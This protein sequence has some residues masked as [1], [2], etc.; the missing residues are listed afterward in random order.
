M[1]HR[2]NS[3]VVY[4]QPRRLYNRYLNCRL[5][6]MFFPLAALKAVYLHTVLCF[7]CNG[8]IHLSRKLFRDKAAACMCRVL[9][10]S[11]T[12]SSLYMQLNLVTIRERTSDDAGN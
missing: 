4:E 3:N 2:L 1:F 6:L 11:K 12:H 10:Q 7:S 9:R 8:S 5:R